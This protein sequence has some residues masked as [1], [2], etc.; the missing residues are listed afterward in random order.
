VL[1]PS[2][3]LAVDPLQLFLAGRP[4]VEAAGTLRHALPAVDAAWLAAAQ[5]LRGQL[6]G[7]VLARSLP[8]LRRELTACAEEVEGFGE[9]L[10]KAAGVYSAAESGAFVPAARR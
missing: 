6:T 7:D 4:L 3:V 10:A 5:A 1:P 8:T 2:A 9:V